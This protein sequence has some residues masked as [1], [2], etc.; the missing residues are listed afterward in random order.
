[1][2]VIFNE[3]KKIF[4]L[5]MVAILLLGSLVIYELFII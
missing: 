5:K 2:K 1:M 3:I 4:N